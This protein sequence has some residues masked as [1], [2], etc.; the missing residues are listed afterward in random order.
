MK[1]LGKKTIHT[2]EIS[3]IDRL[4]VLGL[5]SKVINN[6][7]INLDFEA[8]EKIKSIVDGFVLRDSK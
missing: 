2:F 3:E 7:P 4:I 5:L 8:S 6:E 1:Y